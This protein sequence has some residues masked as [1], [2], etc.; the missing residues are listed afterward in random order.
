MYFLVQ[1]NTTTMLLSADDCLSLL[2]KKLFI[3]GLFVA[4]GTSWYC[5]AERMRKT[6]LLLIPMKL[7]L[8][9]TLK[10]LSHIHSLQSAV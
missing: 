4:G 2:K 7:T 5:A 8:C 10:R 9:W 6:N 3:T 1:S